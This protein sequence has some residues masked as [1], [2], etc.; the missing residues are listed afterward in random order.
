MFLIYKIIT[1]ILTL[2]VLFYCFSVPCVYLYIITI[3]LVHNTEHFSCLF[4][5]IFSK[6]YLKV[7]DNNSQDKF[8]FHCA[9]YSDIQHSTPIMQKSYLNTT[10]PG[11][12]PSPNGMDHSSRLFNGL[13]S[14]PLSSPTSRV[15]NSFFLTHKL[16]PL[17]SPPL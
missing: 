7:R 8:L 1:V 13:T 9:T 16:T 14:T 2:S 12:S 3:L 6:R 11:L 10:K 5:Y 4:W 17:R 15:K